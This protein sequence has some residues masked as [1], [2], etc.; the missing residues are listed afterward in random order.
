VEKNKTKVEAGLPFL[1]FNSYLRQ[2]FGQ[3]VQKLP[4]DSGLGCP[5]RDGTKGTGGCI[6]CGE[7]GSGTGAFGKGRGIQ[8]Q[9]EQGMKWAGRRYGAKKFIA[10]FQSFSNTYGSLKRL[11]KIYSKA[12]HPDVVGLAI[13]TRPDCIDH[14]KLELI[15]RIADGRMVWM[16]YGLQS[17]RDRTLSRINRNHTVEDFIK[18]VRQTKRMGLLT[19]AHIIFGLP[20]E[21]RKDMERTVELL[22]KLQV[23]GVKFHQLFVIKGTELFKMYRKGNYLPM[24]QEDYAEMVAWSINKLPECTVIQRLTGDPQRDELVAPA[25][26]LNKQKTIS[27]IHDFLRFSVDLVPQNP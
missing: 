21:N 5:N 9:L 1:S 17:A 20:G 14:E 4:L 18:A 16:E 25:W 3:R 24:G 23:E 10:Y 7:K 19:C 2:R 26:S 15:S 27:L 8:E 11:E 12:L 13:G 6:Y 22:A